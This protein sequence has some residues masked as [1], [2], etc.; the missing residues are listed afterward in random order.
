L[1]KRFPEI[2]I[3]AAL[4]VAITPHYALADN[5][6]KSYNN[7]IELFRSGNEESFEKSAFS[8]LKNYPENKKV[9]EVRMMLAEIESDIELATERYRSVVNIPRV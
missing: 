6:D 5:S 9:P 2:L 7:L 1:V 8:W 4:A 3:A